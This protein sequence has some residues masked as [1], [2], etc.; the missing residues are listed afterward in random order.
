MDLEIHS[1]NSRQ[2]ESKVLA[3]LTVFDIVYTVI[4]HQ[5]V[6]RKRKADNKVMYFKDNILGGLTCCLRPSVILSKRNLSWGSRTS[7][8]SLR[9]LMIN[10][11]CKKS[12]LITLTLNYNVKIQYCSRNSTWMTLLFY[13]IVRPHKP[14]PRIN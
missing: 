2:N 10:K 14:K 7:R 13:E 12:W 9:H 11:N 3:S 6:S 5:W 4:I 1:R 8:R